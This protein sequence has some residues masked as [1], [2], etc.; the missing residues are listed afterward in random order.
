VDSVLA[1]R[2]RQSEEGLSDVRQK[3]EPMRQLF[4]EEHVTLYVT[5]SFGRLEARYDPNDR[6]KGSDLDVFFMYMPA[7]RTHSPLPRLAWFRLIAAVIDVADELKFKPFSR[8][9]EYLK[10]HN[11]FHVGSELGSQNEDADNGFTARL[12]LL[13][14]GR[15]LV[16]DELFEKVR[17]ETVGFYFRDYAENREKFRPDALINDILRYWRTLCLNYEH[18]REN[19]RAKLKCDLAAIES[20]DRAAKQARSEKTDVDFRAESTLDNLKLRYSRLALCFS[21]ISVLASE[22]EGVTHDRVLERCH[23]VPSERWALA[24]RRDAS[25]EAAKLVPEILASYELFLDLVADKDQALQRLRDPHER[26]RRRDEAQVFGD[27]VF[28][29]ICLVTSDRQ[30]RRLLV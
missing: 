1:A 7:D 2:R 18:Q 10:A 4:Y 21:M 29:L 25:G 24:A 30:F 14:E 23:A 8:D 16:N 13:L 19:R 20:D 26:L 22:P 11:V 5:G 28:Q 12:L 27:R 15:S 9:G 6:N 17:L 3:L